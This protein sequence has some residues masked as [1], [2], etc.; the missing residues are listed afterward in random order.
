MADNDH[1]TNNLFATSIL[2]HLA[3]Q[4]YAN[5]T[6]SQLLHFKGPFATLDYPE[7]RGSHTDSDILVQKGQIHALGDAMLADGWEEY[8]E[9]RDGIRGHGWVLQ[10][11]G[12]M[13]TVDLHHYFPGLRENW[14]SSFSSMW[15]RRH[16]GTMLTSPQ[17]DLPD[18]IDHGILLLLDS[19][20]DR[21]MKWQVRQ[22]RRDAILDELSSEE[23]DLVRSRARMLGI[24]DLIFGSLDPN[25]EAELTSLKRFLMELQH[26]PG[27][28]GISVWLQRLA[29]AE[30][31][32]RRA[33][34]L[35][36]ALV[37][38]NKADEGQTRTRQLLQHWKTGAKQALKLSAMLGK[39]ALKRVRGEGDE[40]SAPAGSTDVVDNN[41][42]GAKRPETTAQ[43]QVP[44]D[45][46]P[47]AYVENSDTSSLTAKHDSKRHHEDC[48]L[49]EKVVWFLDEDVVY[50]LEL[51]NMRT[52]HLDGPGAELWLRLADHRDFDAAVATALSAYPDAPAEAEDQL[53]QLVE[54]LREL[55][56]VKQSQG[57]K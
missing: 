51:A 14:G 6:G 8:N 42:D 12:F 22:A 3:A 11:Q 25:A 44:G 21:I 54:Q 36:W 19:V 20:A 47:R 28:R 29:Y 27:M 40:T 38:P 18:K 50:A 23:Q 49:G 10:R 17:L 7:R 52:V 35:W 30:N 39:S 13:V 33:E 2:G 37:T 24:E 4:W 46:T 34:V 53:H 16:H 31:N 56:L 15:G 57:A 5:E 55:G 45:E 9:N 26:R 48:L 1:S 32:R 43:T 41:E